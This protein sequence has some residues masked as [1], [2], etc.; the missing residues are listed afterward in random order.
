MIITVDGLTGTGKSTR[1]QK[2]SSHYEFVHVNTGL[3][4][5]LNG[6]LASKIEPLNLSSL[7]LDSENKDVVHENEYIVG[8]LDKYPISKGYSLIIP[9][10]QDHCDKRS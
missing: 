9:K 10:R 6:C 8:L 5:R 1:P 3:F 7:F 4:Y 2:L